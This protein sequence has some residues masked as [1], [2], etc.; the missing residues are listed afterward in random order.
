MEGIF[1]FAFVFVA[2]NCIACM[3][4]SNEWQ[5]KYFLLWLCKQCCYIKRRSFCFY[6]NDKFTEMLSELLNKHSVF[7]LVYLIVL[8]I[9]AFSIQKCFSC[10]TVLEKKL[11]REDNNN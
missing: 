1:M 6:L 4:H 10:S 2:L 5:I 3:C 7:L 11:H 8:I 9:M